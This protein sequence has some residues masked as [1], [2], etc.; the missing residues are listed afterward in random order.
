MTVRKFPSPP[1]ACP[2]A[3]GARAKT[4]SPRPLT[5]LLAEDLEL[6]A[7]IIA[8]FLRLDGHTVTVAENGAQAL[9]AL[10]R[11]AFDLVLMDVQMPV[12]DGLEALRRI[13]GG[14]TPGIDPAVPVIALTAHAAAGDR[15]NLL[16]AG[17]DGYLSKPL[18]TEKLYAAIAALAHTGRRTAAFGPGREIAPPD[19]AI[20]IPGLIRKFAGDAKV[21][22]ELL[23]LYLETSAQK[24]GEI[25][26]AAAAGDAA[27]LAR[28]C[29][30]LAGIAASFGLK[31]VAE[32]CKETGRLAQAD[33]QTRFRGAASALRLAMERTNAA[34]RAHLENT[35]PSAPAATPA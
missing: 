19:D 15:E 5:I 18:D 21:V 28:E 33:E 31:A 4:P 3:A 14:L 25:E 7:G 24:A 34:I 16:E 26:A 29:H 17:M 23:T 22:G 6:N 2:R 9:E 35:P 30:S 1:A 10:A 8:Y 11:D 20:D 27:A 13:R 32:A 12:M